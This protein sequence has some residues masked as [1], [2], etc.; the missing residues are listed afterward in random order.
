M[1]DEGNLG[2]FIL[3][4]HIYTLLPCINEGWIH[5]VAQ[6]NVV[7]MHVRELVVR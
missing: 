7:F 1:R 5:Q 3:F 6:Q 4:L 2:M